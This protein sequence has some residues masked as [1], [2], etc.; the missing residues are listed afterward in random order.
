[1]AETDSI[2][3]TPAFRLAGFLLARFILL[4]AVVGLI[5]LAVVL[6]LALGLSRA[7]LLHDIYLGAILQFLK[8]AVGDHLA[9]VDAGNLSQIVVGGSGSHVARLR[10]AILNYPN[11]SLRAV[12]LNRGRIHERDI[13]ERIDQSRVLTNWLANS[14][15]P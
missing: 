15:L 7:L 12:V 1:M 6:A 5:L 9:G 3:F 14:V 10:L 8:A 2:P 13:V 11:E 4:R